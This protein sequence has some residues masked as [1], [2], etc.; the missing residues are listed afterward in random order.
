MRVAGPTA[1]VPSMGETSCWAVHFI[2][3]VGGDEIRPIV[4]KGDVNQCD[5][6]EGGKEREKGAGGPQKGHALARLDIE[7]TGQVAVLF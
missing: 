6:G 4:S 1:S 2:T 3:A 7:R 5:L